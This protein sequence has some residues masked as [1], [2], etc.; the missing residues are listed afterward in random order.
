[1]K[2]GIALPHMGTDATPE[3]ILR[4]AQEAELLGYASLWAG[5]RL[6][7]PRHYGVPTFFSP[8]IPAKD[9]ARRFGLVFSPLSLEE[10]GLLS[11]LKRFH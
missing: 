6:L 3:A 10:M 5:E 4:I 2:I 7:R 1:M 9:S 11:H 8:K